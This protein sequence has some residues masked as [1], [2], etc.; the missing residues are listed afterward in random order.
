[1]NH[2]KITT[3]NKV[4]AIKQINKFRLSNKGQWFAVMIS[5][6]NITQKDIVSFLENPE[7]QINYVYRFKIFDTWVQVVRKYGKDR[8][9]EYSSEMDLNV[10]EFKQYLNKIIE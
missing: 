3:A 5:P 8:M 6:K 1:M 4:E 9:F 2:L 7:N 10:T